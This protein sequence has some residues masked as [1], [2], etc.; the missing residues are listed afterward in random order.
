MV[1]DNA[2]VGRGVE[3]VRWLVLWTDRGLCRREN[4]KS[5]DKRRVSDEDFHSSP[6]TPDAEPLIGTTVSVMRRR[7]ASTRGNM[8]REG[9]SFCVH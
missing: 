8:H 7:W 1:C 3:E 2:R 4:H 9:G 6:R 5:L